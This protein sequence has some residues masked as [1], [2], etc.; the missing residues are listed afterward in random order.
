MKI[1]LTCIVARKK[2]PVELTFCGKIIEVRFSYFA[3]MV[4]EVKAMKGAK[5]NNELKYWTVEN[6]KRNLFSFDILV[7]GPKFQ[8]YL[9]PQSAMSPCYIE[10]TPTECQNKGGCVIEF[11]PL[12][13]N[14]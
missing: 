10:G 7:R 11:K 3:P 5:W 12:T 1:T 4:E 6:C 2:I 13:L 14:K 9:R 8:R